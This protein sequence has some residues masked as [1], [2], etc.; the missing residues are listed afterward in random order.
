M[1]LTITVFAFSACS[2]DNDNSDEPYEDNRTSQNEP[3]ELEKKLFD[4][5]WELISS[6]YNGKPRTDNIGDVLTFSSASYGNYK[7]YDLSFWNTLYINGEKMGAWY[8]YGSK[9]QI[10]YTPW[11]AYARGGYWV[12][13]G[14]G[15]YFKSLSS[16][17]LVFEDNDS[18]WIYSRVNDN[19]GNGGNSKYEK[20]EVYYYD[21]T[22]GTT[23]LK[24]VFEIGN[25]DRTKVT[26]AKGYCGSKSTDGSIG[27]KLITFNFT[28]LS[29]GTKYKIYCRVDGPGGSATSDTVILSTLY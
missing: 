18:K 26:S 6:T 19:S 2:T 10:E 4:T 15:A 27:S 7:G 5:S 16:T 21:F 3:T 25:K 28:G 20:P 22:P 23:T 11:D 24:V 1:T 8:G 17:N 14:I 12:M 29:R 13:Y 9:I